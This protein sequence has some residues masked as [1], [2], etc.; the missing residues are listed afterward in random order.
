MTIFH[1]DIT[2]V[3]KRHEVLAGPFKKKNDE[4][5]FL[6]TWDCAPQVY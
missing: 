4:S 2:I 1:M 6:L 5:L 3:T